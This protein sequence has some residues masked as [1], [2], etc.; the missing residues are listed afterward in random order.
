[1]SVD[2]SKIKVNGHKAVVSP[3]KT[4]LLLVLAGVAAVILIAVYVPETAP[5]V[6]PAPGGA[7]NQQQQQQQQ[8]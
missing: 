4:S 7:G 5:S 1:M 2:A 3:S 8:Q 6:N